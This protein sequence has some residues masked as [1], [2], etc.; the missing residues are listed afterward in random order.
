M[1]AT[2]MKKILGI[3]EI[4]KLD[5]KDDANPFKKFAEVKNVY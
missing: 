2:W 1:K 3:K 4:P 5:P